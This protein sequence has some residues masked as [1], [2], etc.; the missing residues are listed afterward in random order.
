M[1]AR[2]SQAS[3]YVKRK[4]DPLVE[5]ELTSEL[6]VQ[7]KRDRYPYKTGIPCYEYIHRPS[8]P[9]EFFDYVIMVCRYYGCKVHIELQYGGE[10]IRYME[11]Q[12]YAEFIMRRPA[13]TRTS[14]RYAQDSKGSSSSRGLTQIGTGLM[15]RD[16]DYFGHCNFSQRLTEDQLEFDP[17]NTLDH[18]PSMGWMFTL[19]AEQA[20]DT[21]TPQEP[22]NLSHL[23]KWKGLV[24][25]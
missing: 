3:I 6:M 15:A 1:S 25:N 13:F 17:L 23:T 2:K 12:G 5:G 4:Y 18:D 16:V 22:I 7:R 14:T 8:Q 9:E 19:I 24:S 10:L 11:K 21:E 20:E